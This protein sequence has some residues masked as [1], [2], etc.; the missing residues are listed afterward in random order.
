MKNQLINKKGVTKKCSLYILRL[1]AG[2]L[3]KICT[4][5]PLATFS[6]KNSK[7]LPLKFSRQKDASKASCKKMKIKRQFRPTLLKTDTIF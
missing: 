1:L 4:A 3:E 5:F 2:K 7:W 6:A